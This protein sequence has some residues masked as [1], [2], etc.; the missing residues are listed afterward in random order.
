M[1]LWFRD[2]EKWN[3]L[4]GAREIQTKVA[5]RT[6]IKPI[7]LDI[8]STPCALIRFRRFKLVMIRFVGSRQVGVGRKCSGKGYIYI[9]IR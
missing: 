3:T 7:A 4:L 9:A 1:T 5:Y 6:M 2:E 8:F